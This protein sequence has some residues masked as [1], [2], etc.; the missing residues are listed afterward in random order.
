[1]EISLVKKLSFGNVDS[2]SEQDLDRLFVQTADFDKFLT[3]KIWLALGAKG[4]GKSALF[5]FLT[6][7]ERSARQLADSAADGVIIAA[8]T[9]FG[10]LSE[11]ATGDIQELKNRDV[12]FD[13]DR[14]WRLYIAIKAAMA[15]PKEA[16][17]PK[18][19]LRSLLQA[20][21]QRKDFRVGS[22]LRDLWSI[23]IGDPP[24]SVSVSAGGASVQI[25]G[26]KRPLDVVTI[27][28]DLND[29]LTQSGQRVW[30]LFDKVD[31]IWPADRAE[32]KK[33]LEGLITASM[34]IRKLFPNVQP[35]IFL[36]TD[37]WADLEFT[38]KDHLTD[39]RIIL[40]WTADQIATMLLKR[41]I[42]TEEIR[43]FVE[44][45][46]PELEGVTVESLPMAIR[47]DALLNVFPPK[48]YPGDKEAG[49]IEWL[50]ARVADGRDTILPRDAIVLSNLAQQFQE[51]QGGDSEDPQLLSRDAMR[52]AFAE[53]SQVRCEAFLAEFPDLREHFRQFA[54]QQTSEFS[55]REL[56]GMMDGLTPSGDDLL[57][58]LHEIG[59][60]S[61]NSPRVFT[62][63]SFE[64]PRLYRTGLGL[65]IRGR[66]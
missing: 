28:K 61:I 59:I 24:S 18:G 30:L 60:L 37:L 41:A 16:K 39:K 52:K 3:D 9:G 45:R 53:T 32:R 36:R 23:T 64:I 27:L 49:T 21:D 11:I 35:K 6:K 8:G 13:H 2:E 47:R 22:L 40:N 25:S 58:R 44:S 17:V 14:M 46:V 4:T 34:S 12:G 48:V 63:T 62:A 20:V 38:N 42:A 15:I 31:E 7:Y 55:R 54:G 66:P 43:E 26:E 65:V 33:S 1:M 56:L 50:A 19:P 29:V 57:E 5:E 10:D 51:A